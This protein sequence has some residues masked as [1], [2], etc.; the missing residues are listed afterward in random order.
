M[1][2][3]SKISV[4]LFVV[5]AFL[6]FPASVFAELDPTAWVTN[7]CND[8]Y[9]KINLHNQVAQTFKPT[10]N[11][12]DKIG[13]YLNTTSGSASV[14]GALWTSNGVTKLAE[15]SKTVNFVAS[16]S[17]G[18]W[19]YFD[20]SPDVSVTAGDSYKLVLTTSSN[21]A[22]WNVA[23]DRN[24]YAN[25]NA[26]IDS[27]AD[28]SQDFC[29]ANYGYETVILTPPPA[30]TPTPEPTPVPTQPTNQQSPSTVDTDAPSNVD[31]SKQSVTEPEG[32]VLVK[33]KATTPAAKKTAT[34]SAQTK[35]NGI[36]NN[37]IIPVIIIALI[38]LV[39]SGLGYYLYRKNK[40]SNQVNN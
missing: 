39:G 2:T 23:I 7:N 38:A 5:T 29:F 21:A 28:T 37:P 31:T 40:D 18:A 15:S 12:V 13:A 30:P 8:G 20:F 16:P 17:I 11:T 22:Y 34:K 10:K 1:R 25:G 24:S 19:Y 33:N 3:L 35:A 14:T 9:W 32:T 6:L 26:I 4:A 36:F 27:S